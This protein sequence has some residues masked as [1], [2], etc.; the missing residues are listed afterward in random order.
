MDP[1]FFKHK[2]Q[3]QKVSIRRIN[4][5]IVLKRVNRRAKAGAVT[6]VEKMS[7]D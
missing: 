1:P 2:P 4:P 6:F 5:A 3:N 7:S